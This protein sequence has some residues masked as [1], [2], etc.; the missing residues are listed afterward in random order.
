MFRILSCALLV[1]IVSV[2]SFAQ[3]GSPFDNPMDESHDPFNQSDVHGEISGL[4]P[5]TSC[6]VTLMQRDGMIPLQSTPCFNDGSFEFMN[7]PHGEYK[8]VIESGANQYSRRVT[9]LSPVEDL[10]FEVMGQPIHTSAAISVADLE[11]PNKAR[12]ELNKADGFLAKGRWADANQHITKALSI[13]PKYGEAIAMQAVVQMAEQQ[14]QTALKTADK[15]VDVDPML[16]ITQFVRASILTAM[17]HPREAAAAAEEGLR[18]GGTPW[19][20]HYEMAKA[21][22]AE[23]NY[24]RALW[25]ID[26][27]AK[28]AP[29]VPNIYLIRASVLFD[30][31]NYKNSQQDL[32]RYLKSNPKDTRALKLEALL[33][34]RTR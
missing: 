4:P 20:G 31:R 21:M 10:H 6:N 2:F 9:I 28:G 29:N 23:K 12:K 26:R 34:T 3:I 22:F 33:S 8:I 32:K 1:C 14:F 7:V 17:N 19:R 11:V 25:E 16:P 13:Y 18:L 24:K 15:A 5:N 27:A 30:L